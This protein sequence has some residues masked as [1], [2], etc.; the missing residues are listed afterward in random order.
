MSGCVDKDMARFQGGKEIDKPDHSHWYVDSEEDAYDYCIKKY[1]N[2][3]EYHFS[4]VE[5]WEGCKGLSVEELDLE[6]E[7]RFNCHRIAGEENI[8]ILNKGSQIHHRYPID[9]RTV[10]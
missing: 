8:M 4:L 7:Y 10:R 3:G 5:Y 9:S 6:C 1:N 2:V